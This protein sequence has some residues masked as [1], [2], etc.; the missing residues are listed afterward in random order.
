MSKDL[1]W[2]GLRLAKL[3]DLTPRRIQQLGKQGVLKSEARG[4]Y[5]PSAVTDYVRYLRERISD[6]PPPNEFREVRDEQG[7]LMG[8]ERDEPQRYL[9]IDLAVEFTEKALD[10]VSRAARGLESSPGPNG[11]RLYPSHY[12]LERIFT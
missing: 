9:T 12:L 1:T 4:R 7:E 3:L 8:Y 5:R 11:A 2:P 6:P 10:A